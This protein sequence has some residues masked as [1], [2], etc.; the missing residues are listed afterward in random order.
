MRR[1]RT[2]MCGTVQL[3][4]P[5]RP[6]LVAWYDQWCW[7]MSIGD[8]TSSTRNELRQKQ[9]F[10]NWKLLNQRD[11]KQFVLWSI[12]KSRNSTHAASRKLHP[13]KGRSLPSILPFGPDSTYLQRLRRRSE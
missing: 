6:T 2:V 7:S 1:L 8:P 10:V 9:R 5:N 11:C 3:V 4:A 13:A 12:W